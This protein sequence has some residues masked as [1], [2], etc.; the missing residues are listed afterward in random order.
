MDGRLHD[1]ARQRAQEKVLQAFLDE[2]AA[3]RRDSRPAAKTPPP[4][5]TAQTPLPAR[6]AETP[7][8]RVLPATRK[9][10]MRHTPGPAQ[11]RN[12][13][14]ELLAGKYR[15]VRLLGRGGVGEVYEAIHD[16][17][18]LRVAV[19][20]I[21]TEF[22]GNAE[23]AA[24]FLQEARAAAAGGHPGIVH[25]HDVGTTPDGRMYLVMEFLDGEDLDKVL[26][27]RHRMP[28]DEICDILCEVLDAVGAAHAA[29]IVHRDLKPENVYL[30]ATTRGRRI[31]KLVD[32]GIARLATAG[33][34][35]TR[36]TQPGA[37]MGTPYY[38][39]PEQARGE[40]D[41]GPAADIYA[42]G[43]M[44]FEALS[45]R[46][47]FTGNNFHQIVLQTLSAPFPSVRTLCPDVP[48]ELEQVIFKATAR[49]PA[50][51]Y[52][53]AGE[54]AAALSPFRTQIGLSLPEIET[55]QQPFSQARR[56]TSETPQ[57]PAPAR[58]RRSRVFL[59][60]AFGVGLALLLATSLLLWP[61][62]DRKTADV[63]QARV[64]A[65][66][67][68]ASTGVP[69]VHI[70]V[71]GVP[72]TAQVLY[73]GNAVGVDFD[74]VPSEGDHTLQV[75]VPGRPPELRSIRPRTD[76]TVDL[77]PELAPPLAP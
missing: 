54:F 53:D 66:A 3:A 41:V 59:G 13:M 56:T 24:R 57:P 55:P 70:R 16:V 34:A 45:G 58:S 64:P 36:L 18:G 32:F 51:R 49:D 72:D 62:S 40:Q 29:G 19:K 23:L 2:S 22:A 61:A 46:L 65:A 25:V 31:V 28:A 35:A 63:P 5:R 52:A 30:T 68:P 42:V 7:P 33:G 50:A 37:V 6:S 11:A 17:I 9:T 27:R 14:G 15:L 4:G 76:L 47:P 44:L 1:P 74:V 73:D 39:A 48:E 21:R 77:G 71:V 60:A 43:V 38:M 75:T 20:L 67:V 10:P 26:R 8:T 12:P 69:L